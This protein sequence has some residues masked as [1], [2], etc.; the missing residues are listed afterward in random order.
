[1]ISDGDMTEDLGSRP[2]VNV[3]SDRGCSTVA[4]AQR[5]LL[6]YKTIWSNDRI[7]VYHNPIWVGHQQSAPDLSPERNIGTG[8]DTPKAV[9]EHC[10]LPDSI[11]DRTLAVAQSLVLP[12]ALEQRYTRPPGK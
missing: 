10:N 5:N 9:P 12:Q 6:K 3:P 1:V 4:T 8:Y 11:G 7:R 2:D